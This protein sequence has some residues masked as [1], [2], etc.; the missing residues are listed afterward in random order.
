MKNNMVNI[1]KYGMTKYDMD[2]FHALMF[3]YLIFSSLILIGFIKD[4]CHNSG[5][6]TNK[7]FI[8]SGVILLV[9]NLNIKIII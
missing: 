5:Y 6:L 7:Q 2:R 1:K 9:M 8:F 3:Y 4:L